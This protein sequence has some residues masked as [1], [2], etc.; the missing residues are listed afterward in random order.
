MDK[1]IGIKLDGNKPYSD[2]N[3]EY[4]VLHA[5]LVQFFNFANPLANHHSHASKNQYAYIVVL[6]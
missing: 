4:Y 3:G 2:S 5:V 1:N 6:A